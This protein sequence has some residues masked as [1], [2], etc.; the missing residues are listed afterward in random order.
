MS[1]VERL[2]VADE[3]FV[4]AWFVLDSEVVFIDPSTSRL[5]PGDVVLIPTLPPVVKILPIVLLFPTAAKSVLARTTPA[6]T[7]VSTR[8]VDVMFT[9]VN[10]PATYKLLVKV[11]LAAVMSVVETPAFRYAMPPTRALPPTPTPPLTTSAAD[12]TAE[13]S[14]VPVMET[15]SSAKVSPLNDNCLSPR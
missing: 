9:A 2:R 5:K 1:P 3:M 7:L 11:I 10:V 6:E 12:V 8:L 4:E 13:A 14:F 15:F